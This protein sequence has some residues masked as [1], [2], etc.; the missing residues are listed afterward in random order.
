[1][2]HRSSTRYT[3]L[4]YICDI[5][6]TAAAL[7][8]ASEIRPFIPFGEPS[9]P[10]GRTLNLEI[11]VLTTIVWTLILPLAG[12]YEARQLTRAGDEARTVTV[13]VAQATLILAGVMYMTFRGLSRLLFLSFFGLDLVAL[14]VER[15]ALRAVLRRS[16]RSPL[17]SNRVLIIGTNKV[18]ASVGER[19]SDLH[20]IGL[21]LVGY[22]AENGDAEEDAGEKQKQ[23]A[24]GAKLNAP[25]LG[26]LS[27]VPDL[28]RS[29]NISETIIALPLDAHRHLANLVAQLG[30]LPVNI[31]VVPDFFDLVFFHSTIEDLAGMPLI[32]IKEPVLS[33]S[34]RVM[35][36]ILDLTIATAALIVLFP[37]VVI[38]AILIRLDSSG[39]IIFR[40]QR[41]GEGGRLFWM[42]K[43]RTMVANAAE[44]QGALVS[45]DSQGHIIFQK[46]PDDP[47]LTRLG[48]FLRHY[49]IDEIPQLVNVL[50]GEMSLVGPRPELPLIVE[51][52]EPWQRKRFAVPPGMTGW[53]QVRGRSQQPMHLRTE[54]DLYYIQNYSLL[55]DLRILWKTIGAVISGRGAY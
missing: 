27:D 1:M 35:K 15:M 33:P 7:A 23:N 14:L 54:D 32:G 28:V 51:N 47:R 26:T 31:K 12:A 42:Y 22:V 13:G 41:V 9:S 6:V 44:Q 8:L 11:Y 45:R 36:R 18:A 10:E 39:P 30:D 4:L 20:W 48:R 46:R 21:Q 3:I 16:E 34:R 17:K 40:Q 29:H 43:F 53:W 37:L 50:K 25:V 49:S 55:L 5:A 38:T 2:L 24:N 52:Y 19:V